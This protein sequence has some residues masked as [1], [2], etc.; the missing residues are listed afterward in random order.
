MTAIHHLS[1]SYVGD[2]LTKAS[3]TWQTALVTALLALYQK[4]G[5]PL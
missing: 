3:V 4:F 1:Y 5:Y 2:F